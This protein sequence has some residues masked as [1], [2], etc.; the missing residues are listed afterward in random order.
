MFGIYE[1]L[2]IEAVQSCVQSVWP[3]YQEI[4]IGLEGSIQKSI[5]SDS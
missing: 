5:V 4:R 1:R 2:F 3:R